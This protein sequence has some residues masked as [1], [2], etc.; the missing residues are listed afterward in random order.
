MHIAKGEVTPD[1]GVLLAT[2]TKLQPEHHTFWKVLGN[3]LSPK[4][5]IILPPAND[6]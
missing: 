3:D 1:D 4:F 5:A 2:P 6:A